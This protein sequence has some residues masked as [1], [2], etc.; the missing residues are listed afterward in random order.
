MGT[1]LNQPD[2]GYQ[3]R[4]L[5]LS[6]DVWTEKLFF[7]LDPQCLLGT[8]RIR[9][10]RR[11]RAGRNPWRRW[12]DTSLESPQ[13]I[14]DWPSAPMVTGR[15]YRAEPRSVVVLIA[16]AEGGRPEF[17]SHAAKWPQAGG[18]SHDIFRPNP[19]AP[20][21]VTKLV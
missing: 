21:T 2:W 6:A 12:I 16:C 1:K 14:V 18:R 10:A 13:D 11:K 17:R 9:I 7:H 3:S 8:A 4:S 5:A 15:I 19:L 20:I